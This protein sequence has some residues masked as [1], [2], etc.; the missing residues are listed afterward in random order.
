VLTAVENRS[1]CWSE[2]APVMR[3]LR[4]FFAALTLSVEAVS[5]ATA[6]LSWASER[7]TSQTPSMKRSRSVFG[8]PLGQPR[9]PEPPVPPARASASSRSTRA[10]FRDRIAPTKLVS[11][12]G[13]IG[14]ACLQRPEAPELGSQT[15]PVQLI[16][17]ARGLEIAK[18]VPPDVGEPHVVGSA[19]LSQVG[20]ALDSKT[21]RV[22]NDQH[23]RDAIE[24][25][26]QSSHRRAPR[27]SRESPCARR[28]VYVAQSRFASSRLRACAAVSHRVTVAKAAQNESPAV[29]KTRR[30]AEI[31]VLNASWRR[32]GSAIALPLRSKRA[33]S[34]R[35]R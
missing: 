34:R 33:Y 22:P 14:E 29:L 15:G 19:P 21:C 6:S 10:V 25:A 35:C 20:G 13:R 30:C 8:Q 7:S 28:A 23:S 17:V 11:W 31:A 26:R 2:I 12:I 18:P 24:A 3:P 1:T 32:Y 16:D 27:A 5:A 9:F 4:S